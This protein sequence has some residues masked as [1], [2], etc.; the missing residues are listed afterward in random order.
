MGNRKTLRLD[1]PEPGQ[2]IALVSSEPD[3]RLCWLM[4]QH[5]NIHWVLSPPLHKDY[6]P[7]P[8]QDF[9]R[10]ISED[11]H[12]LISNKCDNGVLFDKYRTVDYWILLHTSADQTDATAWCNRLREVPG[13]CAAFVTPTEKQLTTL[14][15]A[16]PFS[17]GAGT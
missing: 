4:L 14:N 7:G 8:G 10:Y 2:V 11:K 15:D 5:L 6:L 1:K 9:T 16:S 12:I 3:Y 13:I 17:C